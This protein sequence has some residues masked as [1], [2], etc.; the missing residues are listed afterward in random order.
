MRL[1]SFALLGVVFVAGTAHADPASDAKDLFERGRSLRAAGNCAE[2]APLFEK[3]AEI[4]PTGLGNVRNAAECEEQLGHFATSHRYWQELKRGLMLSKEEKYDGWQT[5]TEAAIARLAPKLAHVTIDVVE[6]DGKTEHKLS[7]NNRV[8]V[9]I[10]EE[11]L[12][13]PL[14][15]T[16]LDRDPGKYV[17]TV[18]GDGEDP[19]TQSVDL[20]V[21]DSKSLHFVVKAPPPE[22][23]GGPPVT[24]PDGKGAATRRTI[25][26]IGVGVGAA[27]LIGAGIS[28]GIRQAALGDL[29]SGCP[30]YETA[31]CPTSLQSTVSRGATAST[32]VNVLGIAGGVLAVGGIVLVLVSP[33]PTPADAKPATAFVPEVSFGLGSVSASWSFR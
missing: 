10:N 23:I 16:L 2:A 29:K 9:K 18:T 31:A 30:N 15:G 17:V 11:P 32:L 5:D 14:I 24:T 22:P 7:P 27:A 25:G 20:V 28:L 3:A 4:Y 26:W 8:K 21:G 13:R 6:T 33:S 12:Q 19:K 1:L